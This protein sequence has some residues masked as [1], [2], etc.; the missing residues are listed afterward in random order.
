[1][2]E[3]APPF[4]EP[5]TRFSNKHSTIEECGVTAM[6]ALEGVNSS[7]SPKRSEKLKKALEHPISTVQTF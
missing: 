1:V 2:H 5:P 3:T 7:E 4:P 6:W